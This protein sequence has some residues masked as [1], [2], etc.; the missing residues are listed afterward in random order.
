MLK[1]GQPLK[2]SFLSVVAVAALLL[3]LTQARAQI[4][5]A[6]TPTPGGIAP[7]WQPTPAQENGNTASGVPNPMIGHMIVHPP[8]GEQI[9]IGRDL[10]N[11][12]STDDCAQKVKQALEAHAVVPVSDPRCAAAMN[13]ALELQRTHPDAEPAF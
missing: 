1:G 8:P 4:P 13:R 9:L 11:I 2:W 5:T 7:S 10:V 3:C 6:N 12:P